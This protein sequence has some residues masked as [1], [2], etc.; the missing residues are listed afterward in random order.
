MAKK[1]SSRGESGGGR[2]RDI[3]DKQH[4]EAMQILRA[5]YYQGVRS[6][7]HELRDRI[8]SDEIT[9]QDGLEQALHESVDGSYWVIYTHANYQV[10]MCSDNSGAYVE[11][12]GEAPVQGDDINWAALAFAALKRDVEQQ[13]A[14]ENIE[15][16][17][18]MEEARRRKRPPER[19][20]ET[21]RDRHPLARRGR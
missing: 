12:F 14:A 17:G 4:D 11:D 8:K 5:E 13:M 3:T 6:I 10:L 20:A 2:S 21:R 1:R 18:E 16:G 7:A 15:I 9:D 19:P